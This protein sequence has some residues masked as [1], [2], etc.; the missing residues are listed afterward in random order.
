MGDAASAD[1]RLPWLDTPRP[2]R[3]PPAARRA[4]TPLLV[5]LGL[6]LTSG[7]AVMA[8]LAGRSTAP[9]A[10]AP[11]IAAPIAPPIARPSVPPAAPT[12]APPPVAVA[13]IIR[14]VPAAAASAPV[15]AE[16]RAAPARPRATQPRVKRAATVR[17][18]AR[19]IAPRPSGVAVH[20]NIAR[21]RAVPSAYIA[22]R[23]RANWPD[24]P[25]AGPRGRIIQLGAYYTPAQ[26]DAAWWR[27]A[28]A[29]PYLSTLPRVVT[30]IGPS[31]GRPR[32]YRVRLAAGSNREARAL[33]RHLH[34]IGRGCIIA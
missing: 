7:V 1:E 22:P 33:C 12:P 31:P 17:R 6:F 4:R 29:Y 27:V 3:M 25:F 2:V 9:V 19:K 28:R 15:T 24:R 14:P 13:P 20:R 10:A 5:L 26:A 21:A 16:V 34:R 32:Y 8:F 30:R 23:R 18:S 11:E